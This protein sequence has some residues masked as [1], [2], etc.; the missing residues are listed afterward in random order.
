LRG[1]GTSGIQVSLMQGATV[2]AT[3][4]HD[5]APVSW[6]TYSQTLSGAEADSITDYSALRFRFTEV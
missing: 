1:D 2:I 6:T 5:P 4:T 3:W